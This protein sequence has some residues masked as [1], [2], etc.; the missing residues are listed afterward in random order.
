MPG[1]ENTE[2]KEMLQAAQSSG[3][4]VVEG[5]PQTASS[6]T[7]DTALHCYWFLW[8]WLTQ[9]LMHMNKPL[10]LTG[11]VLFCASKK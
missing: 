2:L 9:S 10:K 4:H 8:H 3:K 6:H 1:I 7:T 5:K 11:K